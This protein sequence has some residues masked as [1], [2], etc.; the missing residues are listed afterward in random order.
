GG[1]PVWS[2]RGHEA[3]I[4]SLAFRPDGRGLASG[5]S[6]HRI[7]VWDL[8]RG[9]P[10]FVVRGHGGAINGLAFTPDGTRLVSG[11]ADG[12]AKVW[13]ARDGRQLRRCPGRTCLVF[14]PRSDRYATVAIGEASTIVLGKI[15]DPGPTRT[16]RGHRTEVLALAARGDG[17]ALA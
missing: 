6:D 10:D 3:P 7:V 13:D 2:L 17:Q 4:R 8:S 1:E 14:L 11:S 12:S 9:E 5:D 15:G 16:L